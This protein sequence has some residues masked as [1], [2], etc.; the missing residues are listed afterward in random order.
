[1]TTI[2]PAQM[3]DPD[4]QAVG[5]RIRELRKGRGWTQG[6]LADA[7]AEAGERVDGQVISKWERGEMGIGVPR[8]LAV[9]TALG[10]TTDQILTG[11]TAAP[12][13]G[14]DAAPIPELA[15]MFPP[16]AEPTAAE[17]AWLRQHES[18]HRIDVRGLHQAIM[19][20]RHGMSA[21]QADASREATA[22]HLDPRVP[23]RR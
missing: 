1:M 8:L 16:G 7:I 18:F 5:V 10:V 22:R 3:S 17:L 15:A 21:A 12:D 2:P 9:A 6:Q 20:A 19:G 23:R 14:A 11:R 4:W 13:Q